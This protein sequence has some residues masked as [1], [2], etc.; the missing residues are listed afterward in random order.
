MVEGYHWEK[1]FSLRLEPV[2]AMNN[3]L[4]E[5]LQVKERDWIAQKQAAAAPPTVHINVADR[6]I[7]CRRDTFMFPNATEW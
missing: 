6:F 5:K 7:P 1:R 2:S 3:Q 4:W